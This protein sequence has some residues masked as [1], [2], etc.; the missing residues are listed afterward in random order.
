M[1]RRRKTEKGARRKKKIEETTRDEQDERGWRSECLKNVGENDRRDEGGARGGFRRRYFHEDL[2]RG[3]DG[4]QTI[5]ERRNMDA[6]PT[7]RAGE[8]QKSGKDRGG[9]VKSFS[10]RIK[11][12]ARSISAPRVTRE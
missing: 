8:G 9:A 3:L 5:Q 1:R 10:R 6:P 12:R 7:E 2:D 4:P 11:A